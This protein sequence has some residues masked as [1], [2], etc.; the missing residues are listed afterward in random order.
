MSTYPRI[1]AR[2]SAL[3]RRQ[4]QLDARIEEV[5]EDTTVSFKQLSDDMTASFKQLSEYLVKTEES[6]EERF[7][8][9]EAD[10]TNVKEDISDVK[11]TLKQHTVLLTQILEHLLK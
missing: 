4:T 5:V 11:T 9:I 7:N 2:I 6:T 10:I 1:E 8:K 3:E